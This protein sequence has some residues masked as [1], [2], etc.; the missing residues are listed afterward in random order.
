[1]KTTLIVLFSL[2]LLSCGQTFET[3]YGLNSGVT[4][5]G[6]ENKEAI[7]WGELKDFPQSS[8]MKIK[9]KSDG[10]FYI[11]AIIGGQFAYGHYFK[12]IGMKGEIYKYQRTDDESSEFLFVNY[13]LESL[14]KSNQYDE[15]VDMKMINYR[16]NFG[17]IFKF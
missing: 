2:A 6:I 10:S 9:M 12:F 11:N 5:K 15:Q 4:K 16:T 7:V 3:T 8:Y 14:A 13:S 1:M 17:M